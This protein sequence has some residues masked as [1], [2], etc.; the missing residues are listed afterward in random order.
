MVDTVEK[1]LNP[2]FLVTFIFGR[3]I[4]RYPLDQPRY[5]LNIFYM[6]T[7]WSAYACGVY[8]INIQYSMAD[9]FR[10]CLTASMIIIN[11]FT[12]MVSII[13]TVCKHKVQYIIITT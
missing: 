6:L 8:Y 3:G 2:L 5:R 11:L 7:V 10:S 9:L 13:V 1:I 12:S 4:L